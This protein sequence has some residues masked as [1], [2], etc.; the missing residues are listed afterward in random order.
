MHGPMAAVGVD[1]GGTWIRVRALDGAGR[2]LRSLK[3]PA[4]PLEA[5]PLFLRSVWRRWGVRPPHLAVASRGVWTPS[6][7]KRLA[8]RLR[9]LSPG[10]TVLSDVE[11]A[12]LAAFGSGE[13]TGILI[14]SGTGSI[15]YGRD[16]DGC[17]RRAGGLG[18]LLGDEGSAFWIG[19]EW[20]RSKAKGPDLAAVLHLLRQN[21]FPVRR[22]AS[23]AAKVLRSARRGDPQASQI[24]RQAQDDLAALVSELAATL[25]WKRAI[26]VGW[27]GSLLDNSDFR[28][29]FLKAA[30]RHPKLARRRLLWQKRRTDA[31]TAVAQYALYG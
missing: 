1:L 13:G 30:Q 8:K 9:S 3:R 22:I 2:P 6:E 16:S 21:P 31:A 10:I 25:H 4:V 26:P 24:I 17:A 29:G 5:L 11:A 14:I 20:L 28:A 15:A 19:R 12:W 7:R 27:G 18:P 23:L